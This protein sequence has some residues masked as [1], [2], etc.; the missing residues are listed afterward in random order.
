MKKLKVGILLDNVNNAKQIYD[1]LDVALDSKVYDVKFTITHHDFFKFSS[2]KDNNIS[3]L[4]YV[5]LFI[6]CFFLKLIIK[7]ETF[8][9]LKNKKISKDYFVKYYINC[10]SINNLDIYNSVLNSDSFYR[11]TEGEISKIRSENIDLLIHYGSKKIPDELLKLFPFGIVSFNYTN[12]TFGSSLCAGFYDV[13]NKHDTTSFSVK[14]TNYH[15]DNTE[16]VIFNGSIMTSF[17][18]TLNLIRLYT[19]SNS[20]I[21]KIVESIALNRDDFNIVNQHKAMIPSYS[22]PGISVQ[23]L[24][25]YKLFCCCY[26]RAW[27]SIT[28]KTITWGVAYQFTDSWRDVSLSKSTVIKN[29]DNHYLADPFVIKQGNKHYCFVE[30]YDFA[31]RKGLITVYEIDP[32]GY[33]YLG[34]ALEEEFH[35]SYPY[36]F[37]DGDDIYMCPESCSAKDIRLYKCVNFPLEWKLEK[38]LIDNISAADT[39]IIKIDG[40]WWMM[41]NVDS[42]PLGSD[43]YSELHLFYSKDLLNGDWIEHKN[44]PV[45]YNASMGRNGGLFFENENIYRVYQIQGCD[46]YGKSFG[47][48]KINEI[49][50]SKYEEEIQLEVTADYFDS[51]IATHTYN[52]CEGLMVL[53]F[54][55]M[56]KYHK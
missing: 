40:M 11:Y 20:V 47:I 15:S 14:V 21:H 31:I 41:S 39:N 32:N 29:P 8:L 52:F 54:A 24:Y 12:N 37:R 46:L 16:D 33:K 51:I 50:P 26:I 55:K 22:P 42:S 49:S 43:H 28:S 10:F 48:S 6:K 2:F 4:S 30:D 56:D 36:L 18:F 3:L 13:L 17:I 9:L 5:Y 35:L 25:L 27:R 53:D 23:I 34:V 7:F 38:V 1:L 44:N 45:I 19:K